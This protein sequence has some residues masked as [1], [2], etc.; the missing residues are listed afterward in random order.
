MAGSLGFRLGGPRS[1]GGVVHELPAF[2]DGRQEVSASDI[3]R[4]LELYWTSLNL[5]MVVVFGI[6][7]V[8]WRLV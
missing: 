6:A 8:L 5:L 3:L 1:Y 7:V 4:S 2:G